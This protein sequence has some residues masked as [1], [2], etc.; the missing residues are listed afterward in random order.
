MNIQFAGLTMPGIV[1]PW[2]PGDW[3]QQ[4]QVT[5]LFGLEGSV[6]LYGGRTNRPLSIPLWFYSSFNSEGAL[7][8][9][10]ATIESKIGRIG[11]VTVNAAST[12]NYQN[13]ELQAVR[14]VEPPLPPNSH[15]GWSQLLSLEFLQ[16]R[17]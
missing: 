4:S 1:Q 10:I 3:Q 12:V 9:A 14:H 16:L 17:P 15:I 13:S 6:L 8:D 11:T 5:T 7:N 2:S